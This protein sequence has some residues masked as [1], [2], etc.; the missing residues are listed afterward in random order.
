MPYDSSPI[1]LTFSNHATLEAPGS[2]FN[3]RCLSYLITTGY[4][5]QC[6]YLLRNPTCRCPAVDKP[7]LMHG[8]MQLVEFPFYQIIE[9]LILVH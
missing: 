9:V 2:I 8:F 7:R 5:S 1:A 3:P 4:G 6:Q